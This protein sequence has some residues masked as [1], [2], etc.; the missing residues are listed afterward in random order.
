MI[1]R[2]NK[3]LVVEVMKR[4]D[5]F[6]WILVGG[7]T[8]DQTTDFV[9]VNV[10]VSRCLCPMKV[11]FVIDGMEIE[12]WHAV[13]ENRWSRIGNSLVQKCRNCS[14]ASAVDGDVVV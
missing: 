2:E 9:V 10:K 11:F 8:R 3:K 1:E 4:I 13:W 12:R 5:S 14:F 6:R 7:N